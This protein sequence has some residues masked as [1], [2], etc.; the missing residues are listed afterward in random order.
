MLLSAF[1]LTTCAVGPDYKAPEAKVPAAWSGLPAK[2]V[3]ARSIDI[4][5]WWETFSDP[6]LNSLVERAVA[7]NLDVRI[8]E[9]RLREARAARDVTAADLWPNLNSS[10]TYSRTH[11]NTKASSSGSKAET[12]SQ[13]QSQPAA[14]AQGQAQTTAKASTTSSAKRPSSHADL[15]KAGFDATWEL[16]IFGGVRRSVEAADATIG[17]AQEDYRAVIVS[18]LAE[19]ALNYADL[20]GVQRRITITENNLKTQKDTLEI[21]QARYDAGLTS[22]IDVLKASAEVAATQS[23]I[24]ALEALAKRSV[25]RLGILTGKEPGALL[26]ELSQPR[27]IPPVPLEVPVDLPSDLLRRRPDIAAAERRL[28]AAT[29]GIGV[30]V[31]ELFPKF[32]LTGS[33]GRQGEHFRD[34]RVGSNKTLTYGPE[35]QWPIFEAGRITANIKVQ[36]ARQEQALGTYEKAVLTAL[37]DVENSLVDY[38]NEQTRQLSLS[39]AV[40]SNLESVTLSRDLYTQGLTDF[41]NVLDAQ[42]ALYITQDQL[43]QSEQKVVTNLIA[44]YKA[45]GGGWEVYSKSE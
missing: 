6:M 23:Q 43:V 26:S 3:S 17:A 28:A 20:C 8:A 31:A 18:L 25:H 13:S 12:S 7:S 44:L 33:F 19:V 16:D 14:S 45:L 39:E 4:V 41:L 34:L 42:R 1:T 35:I 22:K 9:A 29:A 10:G 40:T 32:S 30:A 11:V 15:F 37:E 38:S 2:G 36:N 24:P 5:R 21:T 27:P